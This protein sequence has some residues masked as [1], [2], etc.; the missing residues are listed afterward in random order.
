MK[1]IDV[2]QQTCNQDGICAEVCPAGLIDFQKGRYPTTVSGAAGMCIRCGHCVA[3]CPTGSLSHREIPVEQCT[4]IRADLRLSAEQCEQFLRSRRSIR[5]YKDKS[6]SREAIAN[7]IEMARYAPSGYNS[8]CVKWLVLGEKE[9][10]DMLAR[11]I[12]EWMKWMIENMSDI[13]SFLHLDIAV[14]R[15]EE[16]D[17]VILRGAPVVIVAH[18]EKDNVFA[19]SASTIALAHLELAAPSLGLGCCW[20]GYFHAAATT[21]EPM[22]EAL[23]LPDEDQCFGAIMVGYPK[24]TYHRLP[25]RKPPSVTWRLR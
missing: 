24:H 19:P 5:V 13:A 15:W 23:S 11:L 10:L 20:A 7:L 25:I 3:V 1:L 12:A 17:D 14:R 2:N 22:L 9:E 21:F 8:Q 4:P 18:A 16:G 6:V